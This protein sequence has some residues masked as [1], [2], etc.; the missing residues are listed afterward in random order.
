M[1]TMKGEYRH[2]LCEGASYSIALWI[3]MSR[4]GFRSHTMEYD[5]YVSIVRASR[6]PTRGE[7]HVEIALIKQLLWHAEKIY[8]NGTAR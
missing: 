7:N 4:D 6:I 8:G 5:Q 1:D 3:Q 2:I